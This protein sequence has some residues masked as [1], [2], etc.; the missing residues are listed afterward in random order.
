LVEH[1]VI[2]ENELD[3]ID[4]QIEQEVLAAVQFAETSPEPGPEALF[5]NIYV[6]Q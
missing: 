5:E 6:N 3:K 4:D 1:K 2:T